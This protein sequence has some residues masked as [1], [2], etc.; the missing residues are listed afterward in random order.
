[1]LEG[2][3]QTALCRAFSILLPDLFAEGYR[4]ESREAVLLGRRMDLL[5]GSG[6]GRTCIIELKA[7]A[8]PMPQV[9]DQIL[10]YRECWTLSYPTQPTP[11][12]IVIGNKIPDHTK[13]ELSNF[14]I[15][16]RAIAIED[17]LSALERTYA[18]DPITTGLKLIPDDLAKVRHLL[19]D[20]AAVAV[21][22]GLQFQP[23]WSHEKLFL[24]LVTLRQE[25]HKALW[26]K[27][28]YVQLYAQRANCAVLYG[29]K[30]EPTRRAPLHLNP[31]RG[32]WNKSIF[33]Q[34]APAIEYIS[35]DNKGPRRDRHN[36]DHYRIKDWDGFAT[37]L[38][39]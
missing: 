8:P 22:N 38:G 17:V 23:P 32:S 13:D 36:F 9:R 14:G 12:L 31:R 34:I 4:I 15:E 19:S 18:G 11:R 29:L 33:S 1:M 5:L 28:I 21:S 16:S 37:A 25:K 30:A 10:D 27:N 6:D 7:G 20:H 35:T 3:L 24:A 39:F 26:M 2:E